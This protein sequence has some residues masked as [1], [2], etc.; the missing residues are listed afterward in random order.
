MSRVAAVDCGTNSIRL[1][2]TEQQDDQWVELDRQLQIVRLG[3]GVDATGEFHPD[4]LA[5]T[6]V[7]VDSYA[8]AVRDW[9]VP[10]ERIR[11]VATSAARDAQ[12]SEEFF[13]GVEQR[14][15]VRPE[16]I[17]GD[18]EARLSFEGALSGVGGD[19]P[20]LVMDIGG[21]STELVLGGQQGVEFACSLD[22]GSV[23]ITERFWT[24]D[25]P[26]TADVAAASAHIDG[27]LDDCDLDTS[28]VRTWIG[29]AGTATSLAAIHL[30]LPAYDRDRV[31]AATL[32]GDRLRALSE[33]FLASSAATLRQYPSL[34]PQRADVIAAGS[35]IASRLSARMPEL[36]LVVSESDILD[37]IARAIGPGSD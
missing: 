13:A 20:V 22:I 7:A 33:E 27:L 1:L 8:A 36:A 19:P 6:L 34:H 30:G 2:I 32:S 21:G 9:G 10:P 37:G 24:A 4:A 28:R 16:I 25:P 35:L 15:G 23:R 14:L 12:N 11:F 17:S 5:R 26:A 3:Q 18:E 31:H 29:V